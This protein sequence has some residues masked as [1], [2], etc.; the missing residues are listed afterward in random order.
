VLSRCGLSVTDLKAA[1][2]NNVDVVPSLNGR[3]GTG[4]RLN[5]DR[6]LRSCASG[7]PTAPAPP[8]GLVAR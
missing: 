5:I 2:V 7:A 1:I 3:V 4:G 6:A 8:G